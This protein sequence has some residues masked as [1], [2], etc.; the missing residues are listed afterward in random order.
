MRIFAA[1]AG[2]NRINAAIVIIAKERT[3][4]MIKN[5]IIVFIKMEVLGDEISGPKT[6][7]TSDAI[8]I[9]IPEDRAGRFTAIGTLQAINLREDL[10]V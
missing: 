10:F 3:R 7:M 2:S 4:G 6:Q 5:V 9:Y 1:S 8:D